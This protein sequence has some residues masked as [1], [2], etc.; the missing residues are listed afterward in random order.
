[1]R[2]TSHSK[3]DVLASKRR[4]RYLWELVDRD[5]VRV[6]PCQGVGAVNSPRQLQH[7]ADQIRIR[8]FR[9]RGLG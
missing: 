9:P 5:G 7:E 8:P 4:G 1:M 3:T 2:R 6:R